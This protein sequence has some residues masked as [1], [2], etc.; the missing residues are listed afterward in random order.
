VAAR[1]VVV[2]AVNS[3]VERDVVAAKVVAS[4][5]VD[6]AVVVRDEDVAK[7]VAVEAAAVLSPALTSPTPAPSLA[8]A[9]RLRQR[10]L[11]SEARTYL[12]PTLSCG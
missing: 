10:S 8:S 7:P 1:D 11:R 6:A 4:S 3:A 5:V 2:V 12:H 9:H